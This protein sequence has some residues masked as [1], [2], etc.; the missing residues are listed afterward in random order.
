MA[1]VD[2]FT[3]QISGDNPA[4][5]QRNSLLSQTYGGAGG[6][7]A[8]LGS[9]FGGD[10]MS[11]N[12]DYGFTNSAAGINAAY[13]DMANQMAQKQAAAYGPVNGGASNNMLAS[14]QYAPGQFDTF[15]LKPFNNP[16]P[17]NA[18]GDSSGN[19]STNFSDIFNS[20]YD[21]YKP[22]AHTLPPAAVVADAIDNSAAG[23]GYSDHDHGGEGGNDGGGGG[24]DGGG[25]DGGGGGGD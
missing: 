2:P 8:G 21:S 12:K 24:G 15:E 17:G 4:S 16:N 23:V 6:Y 20:L 25:G 1:Y 14:D 10:A 5:N 19:A 3:G 13:A 9:A 22:V 7:Q 11:Y 18:S